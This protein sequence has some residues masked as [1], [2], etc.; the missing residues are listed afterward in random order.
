M[1]K[2]LTLLIISAIVL[3]AVG[4][5]FAEQNSDVSAMLTEGK[6]QAVMQDQKDLLVS[7]IN[8]N[9][10]VLNEMREH[11][12][13]TSEE[14]NTSSNGLLPA[15]GQHEMLMIDL[16]KRVQNTSIENT[17]QLNQLKSEAVD[18]EEQIMSL[19]GLVAPEFGS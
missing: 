14:T 16:L 13:K 4:S 8:E 15:I 7:E 1:K 11:V 10:R 5:A 12:V 2:A 19:G 18:L 6:I 9:I 3:G 17:N